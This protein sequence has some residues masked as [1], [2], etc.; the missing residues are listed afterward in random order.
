MSYSKLNWGILAPGKI[1]RKF[2]SDLQLVDNHVIKSV[3][4]RDLRKAEEFAN[5]FNAEKAYGEYNA[6]LSDDEVDIVYIATLHP[7]HFEWC[8]KLLDAGKHV[9]CEKPLGINES[10]VLAMIE[11]SRRNKRFLMEAIWSKFNPTLAECFKRIQSGDLGEVNYVNADFTF[12]NDPP[13]DGRLLNM[14]LAGGALLD[15]TIY[16]LFLAYTIFGL[17]KE[18]KTVGR[19][20]KTGAD[21]QSAATLLFDNGIAQITG[22][23]V[24]NSE[25]IAKISGPKGAIYIDS[26]WHEAD[27]YTLDLDGERVHYDVPKIGKGYSHEIIECLRCLQKGQIQSEYWSHRNS[28]DM[29]RMMDEMRAQ[30]GLKYPFEE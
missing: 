27:G 18:I 7:W 8:V 19:F 16:P 28:L 11:A 9:L 22:S 14:D 12:F 3:A 25:M 1:A 5:E 10:E 15:I 23:T 17:P 24:C 20:H 26:R 29:V 4:S 6:L 21:I 13:E 30:I 2:A